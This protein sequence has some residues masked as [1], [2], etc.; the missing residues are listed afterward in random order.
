VSPSAV[1]IPTPYADEELAKLREV[2]PMWDLELSKIPRRLLATIAARDEEIARL[3]AEIIRQ[4]G[5]IERTADKM[6]EAHGKGQ[7]S[8]EGRVAELEAEVAAWEH[9]AKFYDRMEAALE[10]IKLRLHGPSH[11]L[12]SEISAIVHAALESK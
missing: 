8:A 2:S 6:V 11:F 12:G 4:D 3:R 7:E 5:L 10:A 9:T 1:G